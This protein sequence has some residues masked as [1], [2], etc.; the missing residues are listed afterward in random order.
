MRSPLL[1]PTPTPTPTP[2][3]TYQDSEF[4]EWA[5]ETVHSIKLDLEL[6]T[7]AEKRLVFEDV[8]TYSR[9]LY[10]DAE[11]ALNEIDQ[12][13]VSPTLKPSKDEFKLALQDFKLTGYYREKWERNYDSDDLETSFEYWES[14][15]K[16]LKRFSDLLP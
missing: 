12:F 9:I 8:G 4:R 6:M 11:K 16:H 14:A 13:G 1:T 5:S 3:L 15:V 7:N 2:I 10:D